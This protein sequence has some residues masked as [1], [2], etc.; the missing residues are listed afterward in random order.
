VTIRGVSHVG[1]CVSDLQRSLHFYVD[2]LGFELLRGFDIEGGAWAR[3]MEV[4][5]PLLHSRFLRRDRLTIELLQF[6]R[7]GHLGDGERRPLNL[8]GFTHLGVWVDDLDAASALVVQHGGHVIESTG[9][10]LA[11]I[12][13]RW[14]YCTDPDGV[15]IELIEYPAGLSSALDQS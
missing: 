5:D 15:R 3:M 2:G 4:D 1:M 10:E 13:G 11:D 6:E 8:L 12:G 9:I 7:P 14:I